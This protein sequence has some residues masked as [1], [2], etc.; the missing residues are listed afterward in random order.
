MA[1]NLVVTNV[2]CAKTELSPGT[3][4]HVMFCTDLTTSVQSHVFEEHIHKTSATFLQIREE[5]SQV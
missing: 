5:V 3:S 1:L 2:G 4:A